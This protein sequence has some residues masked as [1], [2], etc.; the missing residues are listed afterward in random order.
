MKEEHSQTVAKEEASVRIQKEEDLVVTDHVEALERT[1]KDHVGLSARTQREELSV[2]TDHAEASVKTMTDHVEVSERTARD[3]ADLSAR[4]Q[5]EEV[6]VATDHAEALERIAREEA[7]AA[8][9]DLQLV[10]EDSTLLREALPEES[11]TISVMRTR[12]ESTR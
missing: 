4:T 12:A 9:E 6:L 10:E 7:S 3:H 11:S 1:A 5:R 8:A 2:V